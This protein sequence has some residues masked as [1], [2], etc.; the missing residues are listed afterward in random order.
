MAAAI[1]DDGGSNKGSTAAAQSSSSIERR[2]E[3]VRRQEARRRAFHDQTSFRVF[4][5]QS[6]AMED[7]DDLDGRPAT[8]TGMEANSTQQTMPAISVRGQL[9]TSKTPNDLAAKS[10]IDAPHRN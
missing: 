9:F 5:L 8:T 3:F 1:N 7:Y 2:R 4:P 10:K 6:L